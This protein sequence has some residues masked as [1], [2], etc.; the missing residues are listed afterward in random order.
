LL[1]RLWRKRKIQIAK[2]KTKATLIAVFLMLTLT[3]TSIF[4]AL[5]IVNA[6]TPAW[7]IPT[8]CYADVTNPII[9]VGQQVNIIFW[10]SSIPPTA[11]DAYG[12]RWTFTVE[13][14]QP[15]GTKEARSE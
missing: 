14:T 5:P 15:D 13:V 7:A 3:V 12:D 6:H 10:S 2:N 11:Q 8:W 4:V 9:G 1:N